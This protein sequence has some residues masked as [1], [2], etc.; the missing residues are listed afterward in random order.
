MESEILPNFSLD[1]LQD[2]SDEQLLQHVHE[3]EGQQK[4]GENPCFVALQESDL[5][6]IV[7]GAEAKS[8]KRNTKWVIKTIEGKICKKSPELLIFLNKT[9]HNDYKKR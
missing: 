3:M 5:R 1:V 6:E 9:K 4:T 7:A 8:T 2:I